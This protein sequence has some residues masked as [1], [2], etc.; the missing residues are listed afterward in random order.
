[1]TPLGGVTSETTVHHGTK[2]FLYDQAGRL[3]RLTWNDGFAVGY[4]YNVAGDLMEVRENPQSSG[5][6]LASFGYNPATAAGQLGLRTSLTRGNGT[7]TTYSYDPV[8]RLSQLAQDFG[9]TSN[10]ATISLAYNPASQ[11]ANQTRSNDAYSFSA[12]TNSVRNDTHNGLNQVTQSGSTV[13]GHDGRGNVNAVGAQGYTYTTDNRLAEAA[14]AA[15]ISYDPLGRLLQVSWT[16]DRHFDSAGDTIISEINGSTSAILRRYVPGPG[17]DEPLVWYEGSGTTDR[18]WLHADERGSVVAVS[19]GSGNVTAINRYDEYG[20]PQGTLTG[21]F[22]FTGQPWL[23]E[24]GLYYYRARMYNPTLGRFMQTD[25]IGYGGGMNL[26]AYVG[27]DPVNRFDPLGLRWVC[28]QQPGSRIST[29]QEIEDENDNG[30]IDSSDRAATEAWIRFQFANP[31][32]FAPNSQERLQFEQAVREQWRNSYL[33]NDTAMTRA[34]ERDARAVLTGRMTE[35]EYWSRAEARGIG[36]GAGLAILSALYGGGSLMLSAGG[37]IARQMAVSSRFGVSSERFGNHF[38]R[39]IFGA[40]P[41][42]W[43]QGALRLGWSYNHGVI[44]F[45]ARVGRVHIPSPIRTTVPGP[46]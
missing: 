28:V 22:G 41:G 23:P 46:R 29:C 38:F 16:Q 27:N 21:R 8:S 44:T 39:S 19:D 45:Q 37:A 33:F 32:L 35:A 30:R 10:D 1:M 24:V 31:H 25:P 13:V 18:R 11:I 43:N 9:G 7:A 34:M 4:A 5:M 20:V 15:L 2:S 6:A 17:I 14:G 26:Y 3:T 36:T 42:T 40:G 12:L